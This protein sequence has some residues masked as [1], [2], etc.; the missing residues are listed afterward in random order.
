MEQG[1]EAF[2]RRLA[3]TREAFPDMKITIEA[4]AAHEGLVFR[5]WSMKGTHRGTFLGIQPTGRSVTL[6]GVDIERRENGR[7]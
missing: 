4:R 1:A 3:S 6:S 5:H 7:V 2:K